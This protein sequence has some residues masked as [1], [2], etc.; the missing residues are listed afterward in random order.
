V[1]EDLLDGEFDQQITQK[2]NEAHLHY[3]FY[4]YMY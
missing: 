3:F 2:T 4:Q 1:D